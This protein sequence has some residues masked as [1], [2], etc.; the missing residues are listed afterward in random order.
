MAVSLQP[1]HLVNKKKKYISVGS[2]ALTSWWG[3]VGGC[4]RDP[5]YSPYEL[6]L[7]GFPLAF[8]VSVS[9]LSGR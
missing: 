6:C 4:L 5:L 2:F 9:S 3:D 7:P 1:D 8:P